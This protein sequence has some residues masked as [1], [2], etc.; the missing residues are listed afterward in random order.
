MATYSLLTSP[1]TPFFYFYTRFVCN[2][3]ITV[4]TTSSTF[5]IDTRT[6]LDDAERRVEVCLCAI[7]FHEYLDLHYLRRRTT[8][9]FWVVYV[10]AMDSGSARITVSTTFGLKECSIGFTSTNYKMTIPYILRKA[11][12]W[13]GCWTRQW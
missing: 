1:T 8:G 12:R 5:H 7:T 9:A 4:N 10:L 3:N 11:L 2:F 6:L 13:D